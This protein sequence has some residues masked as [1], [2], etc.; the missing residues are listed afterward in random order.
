MFIKLPRKIKYK[1]TRLSFVVS[2]VKI[3]PRVSFE[4]QKNRILI[5]LNKLNQLKQLKQKL[6][7]DNFHS[8]DKFLQYGLLQFKNKLNHKFHLLAKKY[9]RKFFA[10]YFS[11]RFNFIQIQTFAIAFFTMGAVIGLYVLTSEVILPRIYALN[12]TSLTMPT[13]VAFN[14]GETNGL[15]AYDDDSG[16]VTVLSDEIRIA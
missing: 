3:I 1:L 6:V 10:R 11:P 4:K 7:L 15:A 5:Q 8:L 14:R 12:E 9:Y 13:D 16:T 2:K